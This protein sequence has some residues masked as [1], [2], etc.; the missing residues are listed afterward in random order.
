MRTKDKINE[1]EAYLSELYE[2]VPEDYESYSKDH[3]T[4]AA[5][6]R[7]FEKIIEAV[8]DVIFLI[9]KEKKLKTPQDD[10]DAINLISKENII[11]RELANK[12]K[13]AKSMRNIIVHEYGKINDEIVFKSIAEELDNDIRSFLEIIKKL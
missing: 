4:K 11:P 3:K 10:V 13:L 8:I 5:C 1:I 7:Y 2:I 6:E 9:I 12:L